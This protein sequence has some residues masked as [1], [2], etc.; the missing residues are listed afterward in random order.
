MI[1]MIIII[2]IISIII[3]VNNHN[4]NDDNDDYNKH[5]MDKEQN[6]WLP[7][8][9]GTNRVFTEGPYTFI[10]CCNMLF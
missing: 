4:G 9:V 10:K 1:I 8:G 3:I 6:H 7:D 5:D 2:V